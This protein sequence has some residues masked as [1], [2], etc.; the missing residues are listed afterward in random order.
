MFLTIYPKLAFVVNVAMCFFSFLDLSNIYIIY[1]KYI[2][3]LYFYKYNNIH[4]Y[5]NLHN[6]ECC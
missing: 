4:D 6:I 2:L 5:Y 1:N 3:F